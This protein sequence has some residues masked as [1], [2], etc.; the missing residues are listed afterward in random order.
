[1]GERFQLDDFLHMDECYSME[2]MKFITWKTYWHK[3]AP[4]WK[5]MLYEKKKF[6]YVDITYPFLKSTQNHLKIPYPLTWKWI[7]KI[8]LCAPFHVHGLHSLENTQLFQDVVEMGGGGIFCLINQ[9]I[10]HL[11]FK[12]HPLMGIMCM[13]IMIGHHN[14]FYWNGNT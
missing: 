8:T 13:I 14:T 12:I 7:G 10:A 11:W 9:T 1:M 2:W 5:N 6:I 4:M 3:L